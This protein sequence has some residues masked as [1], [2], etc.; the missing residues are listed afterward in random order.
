MSSSLPP[1]QQKPSSQFITLKNGILTDPTT[2]LPFR[3]A[4]YNIPNLGLVEDPPYPWS[5]PTPYEQTDTLLS[6]QQI[7]GRVARIYTL[8]IQ[9]ENG[10]GLLKHVVVANGTGTESVTLGLNERM[11]VVMDR[12]LAIASQHDVRIIIPFIDNWEWWGGIESFTSLHG[13]SNRDD[14]YTSQAIR[15]SFLSLITTIVERNNTI[16]GIRYKNDP[17]ILAWETGNELMSSDNKKPPPWEWTTSIAKHV[18]Q[19]DSNH[20]FIDGGYGK[21][22]WPSEVLTDPNVDVLS[23]HYYPEG[24][25]M[26]SAGEWVGI[27]LLVVVFLASTATFWTVWSKPEKIP[28]L[29]Q[30]TSDNKMKPPH[31][32]RKR[33]TLTLLFLLIILS[34]S[35]TLYITITRLNHPPFIRRLH[36]DAQLAQSHGKSL[37]IGEFGLAPVE[38]CAKLLDEI[39]DGKYSHTVTGAL[40]WSLRGHS[41]YGGFYTHKELNGYESYHHPGFASSPGFPKDEM[42]MTS[43]I[44][45]A[46][47]RLAVLTNYSIPLLTP[48]APPQIFNISITGEIW[49]RGSTGARQYTVEREE[50]GRNGS[51]KEV[52]VVDGNV[53]AGMPAFVV[54]DGSGGAGRWRVR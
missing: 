49:W 38:D 15:A 52:G 8:S 37:I 53:K 1:A 7:G 21:V 29:R 33:L 4:T 9:N 40:A 3:F 25:D 31:T 16:T 35:L 47:F 51:W 12:A 5:L 23:N 41:H 45:A 6:I 43:L 27:V 54:G 20:L 46:S 19:I 42:D 10:S 18:R 22:G 39:I 2:S 28:W 14:F 48:P 17:T 26:F 24:V 44:R 32:F 30:T 13:S 50:V 34:L 36:H 11:M